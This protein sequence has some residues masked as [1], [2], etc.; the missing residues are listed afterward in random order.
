MKERAEKA[1]GM[2]KKRNEEKTK[3]KRQSVVIQMLVYRYL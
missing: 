3:L 2:T 1:P